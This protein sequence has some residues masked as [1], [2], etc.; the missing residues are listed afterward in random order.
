MQYVQL[1]IFAKMWHVAQI[2]PLPRAQAQ[3]LMTNCSWFL[4][5]AATFRVPVT[6]LKL[7][8]HEGGWGLPHV[9]VNCETLLCNRVQALFRRDGTVTSDH[10]TF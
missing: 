4:W 3:Q 10:L 6:T 2:F 9:K 7:S 5:Q 8:K 1:C